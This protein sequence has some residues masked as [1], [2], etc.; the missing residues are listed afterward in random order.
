MG[1][2]N[3]LSSNSIHSGIGGNLNHNLDFTSDEH[4]ENTGILNS[5]CIKI[6]DTTLHN[7]ILKNNQTNTL[8]EENLV[9]KI[10]Q[11]LEI[12]KSNTENQNIAWLNR[13]QS[14]YLFFRCVISSCLIYKLNACVSPF[15][16]T[17]RRHHR[18]ACYIFLSTLLPT[19]TQCSKNLTFP[20]SFSLTLSFSMNITRSFYEYKS[21]LFSVFR[22][23]YELN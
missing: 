2:N 3:Y 4:I 15:S 19:T 18:R 7:S 14:K 23:E 16:F 11:S 1:I 9:K 10:Q 8:E 13:L 22:R 21:L 20:N 6:S 5:N 12:L 17:I